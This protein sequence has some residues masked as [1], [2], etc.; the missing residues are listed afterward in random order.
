MSIIKNIYL[1]TAILLSLNSCVN[2]VEYVT[3]DGYAQSSTYHIVCSLSNSVS[4]DDVKKSISETFRAIDNSLSGYN[5]GSLLSKVNRGID[6]RLDSIFVDAYTLSYKY[7]QESSGSFDPSASPFFDLWGFGFKNK[8]NVTREKIDSIFQYVGMDKTALEERED[9]DGVSY[10]L[11]RNSPHIS[12]NFNAMAQ[13]FTC[14]MISRVLDNY[15]SLNY[16]IEIGGGEIKC[17]GKSPRGGDWRIG[18]DKPTDGNMER[19]KT[20]QEII[21]ITDK[22]VVTSGNYRKYYIENGKKY[23]HTIDPKTGYP[24]K[25]N[26]LS[27]TVIADNATTADAYATWF[28]VIGLEKTKAVLASHQ[29]LGVYLVYG[30][31]DSMCVWHTPGLK[32]QNEK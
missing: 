23:S 5:K 32:L 11:I 10:H 17:K 15:G 2:K 25:H 14:D 20:L 13:G 19:G 21:N 16:I 28:M 3:I 24:V 8:E 30:E 12:L 18:I 27:A 4:Q 1:S 9:S 29:E 7:W 6:V 22:G 26:L 31:Q